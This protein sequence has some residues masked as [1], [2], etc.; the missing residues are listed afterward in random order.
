MI[1]RCFSGFSKEKIHI[2]Y[3]TIVRPIMEYASVVWSPWNNTDK[4]KLEKVQ[5][6]CLRLSNE[7]ITLQSLEDRRKETDMIETFKFRKDLYRTPSSYFFSS[8]Q[9]ILRG[10]PLK[11]AKQY[12]RVDTHK[13]FFSQRVVDSFNSLP[14]NVVQA[15]TVS[16]FKNRL[17]SLPQE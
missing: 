16:S 15:P 2:L 11:I 4:E 17:R 6:R 8:P 12:S 7:P 1:R 10:H 3:T 14:T 5:R 13:H 9:R